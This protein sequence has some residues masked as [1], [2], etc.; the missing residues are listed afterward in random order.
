[1]TKDKNVFLVLY[2]KHFG[3]LDDDADIE[4][5]PGS[6]LMFTTEIFYIK[7]NLTHKI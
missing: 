2:M 4:F 7:I 5:E 3:K 6:S 1:M